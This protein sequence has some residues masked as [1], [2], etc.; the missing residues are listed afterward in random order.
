MP[1]LV[2]IHNLFRNLL[3]SSRV[4][5][6][7]DEEVQ[8]HLEMLVE[9]NIRA[10]MT[11]EEA[12]RAGRIELGGIEQV[13]EQVREERIG[14]W[15]QSVLADCRFALRQLGKSPAFTLVA[16]L[17]LALGIG[18]TT[19]IFSVVNPVLFESLPYLHANRLMAI[20][21]IRNDGSCNAASF[22]MYHGLIS[23]Q[24]SFESLALVRPWQPTIT[25]ADQPER[26]E[27]QRVTASY[28]RVL[29]VAPLLGRDFDPSEDRLN[30]PNVVVLSDAFWRRRFAGD[31]S[32]VG[33]Q[34]TLEEPESFAESNLYTVVGVMPGSFENVL[35]PTAQLWVPLQYDISQG[36]AWGH[37]LR[38]VGRLNRS[39]TPAQAAQEFGVLGDNILTGLHPDS[40][41]RDVRFR[42]SPLQE[43]LTRGVRPALLAIL[44]AVL[45][46]LVIAC[47]NVTNL[48]LGRGVL[49]QG[50]FA[51]RFALGARPNR[52]IRQL[53]TESM[54]L[55]VVGG[56]FGFA[57]A[58]LC[59]RALRALGP[60]DLPRFS[61][62]GIDPSVFA[63]GFILSALIGT[64]FGLTP[65]LQVARSEPQ[66]GLRLDS[67]RTV[68]GHRRLRG[69]L[70][71]AEV[72]L[73]LVLL[74][75]SGL[76]LRSM[77][78]LFAVPPGFH[79]AHLLTMQIDEVGHRYDA[80]STRYRFYFQA[81]DAIRRLPGVTSAD[82]TSQLP[83]S[84]DFD[85]YGV[86]LE[87]DNDP[88]G[89]VEVFRYAVTPGYFDTLGIPLRNGRLLNAQD[90]AGA[91]PVAVISES[92]ARHKFANV[93]PM[94]Q[95]IRVGNPDIWYT[96][97]GV[98]ADVRQM[99][100]ALSQS[101]AVY[102]TLDQ[103]H[104]V[105]TEM[106]LVVR[107]RGE[108]DAHAA[109]IRSAIWS[110]DKDQPIMRIATMDS[111]LSASA[112]ER[113]FALILFETF[114]IVSLLLAAAGIY[115]VLSGMVA[116]RRR[117]MGV[118]SALGA[119]RGNLVLLVVR[120]GLSLAVLGVAVGLL[121][122]VAA[123][124]LIATMLFGV[125]PL[126]PFTYGAVILMLLG[127]STIAC[128]VPAWRAA[129]VDPVVTLRYE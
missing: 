91:P 109:D 6:D 75:C 15:F 29:G 64:A 16:V 23:Q 118:R 123:S 125:S 78:T 33:R 126:D 32:I 127:V 92:F 19:A 80:D 68:G 129:R 88:R 63:F 17:T 41:G 14:S 77:Q 18:A 3:F 52:M 8:S 96:V 95:R 105:D 114:A 108:P 87:R 60:A 43:D 97:V 111:L 30:G 34:V 93:D 44:A 106:S 112:A 59:V 122:A 51:L 100:L 35:S 21:E 11:P 61:A 36:R 20:W 69:A 55:A 39:A 99:S 58:N 37:H 67:H 104:W 13:K 74:V 45:L 90:H 116:E 42:I 107:T 84:G 2:K 49:R 9:E 5:A 1:F 85:S 47:V 26:L 57:I 22:A 71:V 101:D 81:L 54:L 27:G 82:L 56:V 121:G 40:Y 31:P 79:S 117:E 83:L 46:L 62:I 72:S 50:E 102:T 10:G 110:V 48:L 113:R 115:G 66:T 76:L 103:W 119:T 128:S 124:Y 28:F 53:L 25:G 70:V 86:S 89:D 12:Q 94:G 65:A 120:Q 7:L 73:T 38:M 24:H 98:V 4:E